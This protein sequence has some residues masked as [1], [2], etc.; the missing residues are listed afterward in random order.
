MNKMCCDGYIIRFEEWRS[1][2]NDLIMEVGKG[3]M[4][5]SN[6]GSTLHATL[7]RA[8]AQVSATEQYLVNP[9]IHISTQH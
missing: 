8:T 7:R 1:G 4:F 6:M 9:V 3:L 2:S 5:F